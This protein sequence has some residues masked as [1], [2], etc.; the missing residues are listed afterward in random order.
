MHRH[1]DILVHTPY[2]HGEPRPEALLASEEKRKMDMETCCGH[3][4]VHDTD[5]NG[6]QA[7]CGGG[8]MT[9]KFKLVYECKSKE[10]QM[11]WK[12]MFD[13]VIEA[14][15]RLKEEEE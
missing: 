15:E 3:T 14:V 5:E 7:V 2:I 11:R 10:Q 6:D 4:H 12:R 9:K 1:V 13:A 8:R